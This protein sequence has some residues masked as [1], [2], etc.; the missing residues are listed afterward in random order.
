MQ[1]MSK[2][3]YV[4]ICIYIYIYVR[5]NTLGVLVEQ[6]NI[7]GQAGFTSSTVS[8][9]CGRHETLVSL[10]LPAVSGELEETYKG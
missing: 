6:H 7:R 3:V 5:T 4:Y 9:S 1:Y 2:H 8:T 10:Q